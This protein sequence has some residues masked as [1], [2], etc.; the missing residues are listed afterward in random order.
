MVLIAIVLTSAGCAVHVRRTAGDFDV[1]RRLDEGW[2]QAYVSHDTAF[3]AALLS[4]DIVITSADGALK[5][6]SAELAD[7]AEA[8]GLVMEY[9]HTGDV[10]I[11]VH[12]DAA[13]V[14]GLAS[15]KYTFRGAANAFSRRYTATYVRGGRLGWKIVALQLGRAPAAAPGSTE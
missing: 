11:R 12:G 2:A 3:A 15:W 6:K 1:I 13:V 7:V 14:A 9:F 5:P 8:P 10:T 4:D